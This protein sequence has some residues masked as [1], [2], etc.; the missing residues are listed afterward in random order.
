MPADLDRSDDMESRTPGGV[1]ADGEPPVPRIEPL[2]AQLPPTV[3]AILFGTLAILLF[4]LLMAFADRFIP[5]PQTLPLTGTLAIMVATGYG[6]G[7]HRQA[8]GGALAGL[9]VGG[10]DALIGA[11][12]EALVGPPG[13][14]SSFSHLSPY[15]Y[16]SGTVAW[17]LVGLVLGLIGGLA[18][19]AAVR[20]RA[21]N[22][23]S[24]PA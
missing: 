22:A 2:P 19:A 4:D 7:L 17:A 20:L 18:G 12:L 13:R 6:A 3:L 9:V 8:F 23:P 16:F 11:P 1:A 10:V 24:P 14:A 21:K 15:A 5:L